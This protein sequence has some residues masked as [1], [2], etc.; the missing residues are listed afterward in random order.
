MAGEHSLS[1]G[2]G[3][4]WCVAV[5]A[6]P[7]ALPE[8]QLLLELA[9]DLRPTG[10]HVVLCVGERP[11]VGLHQIRLRVHVTSRYITPQHNAQARAGDVRL[12]TT[13]SS[14]PH[15]RWVQ[16]NTTTS[17]VVSPSQEQWAKLPATGAHQCT[18][19]QPP[20]AMASLM[21]RLASGNSGMMG[22]PGKSAMWYWR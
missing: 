7:H 5:Q 3:V 13:R 6:A 4:R 10:A 16:K 12:Q 22:Q 20:D 2:G 14:R 9:A 21:K 18:S 19:T 17:A 11:P 1:A 8:S 15:S